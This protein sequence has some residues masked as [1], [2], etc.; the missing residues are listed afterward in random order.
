MVCFRET[1]LGMAPFSSISCFS[2]PQPRGTKGMPQLGARVPP[3]TTPPHLAA[4]GPLTAT[5]RCS[6]AAPAVP[7]PLQTTACGAAKGPQD[8]MAF[9][10]IPCFRDC[11]LCAMKMLMSSTL[12]SHMSEIAQWELMSQAI[13]TH[14]FQERTWCSFLQVPTARRRRR[15]FE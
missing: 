14:S 11:A 10:S 15:L 5:P 1:M 8:C 3:S 2:W 12:A 7:G 9:D 6:R 13:N 4:P